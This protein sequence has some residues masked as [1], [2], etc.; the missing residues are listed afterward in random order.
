MFRLGGAGYRVR[1]RMMS[2]QSKRWERLR[3]A[4]GKPSGSRQLPIEWWIG[5][6]KPINPYLKGIIVD[7]LRRELKSKEIKLIPEEFV[8]DGE[9][10][11]LDR[12]LVRNWLS[13][14]LKWLNW[15]HTVAW[16]SNPSI[17]ALLD[18][19][20]CSNSWKRSNFDKDYYN[21]GLVWKL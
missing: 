12:K 1:S 15:Y 21:F 3:V 14:W 18:A 5:R 8:F 2:T 19:P 4:I 20:I 7:Y 9:K 17:D 11:I 6:G 10:E 16:G 13:Q